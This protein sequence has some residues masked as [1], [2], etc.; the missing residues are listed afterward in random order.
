MAT[1]ATPD[2]DMRRGRIVQRAISLSSIWSSVSERRPTFKTRLN[3][4]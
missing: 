3:E 2:T 4:E 1:L